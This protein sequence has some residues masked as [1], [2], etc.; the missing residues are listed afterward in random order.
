MYDLHSILLSFAIPICGFSQVH[1]IDL[2]FA[3]DEYIKCFTSSGKSRWTKQIL[4]SSQSWRNF[5][6]CSVPKKKCFVRSAPQSGLLV[7][8]KRFIPISSL[9]SLRTLQT[10]QAFDIS[11]VINSLLPYQRISPR[12]IFSLG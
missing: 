6:H 9:I 11:S 4:C 1:L 8:P 2:S 7:F 3:F 5:A 12:C 10:P